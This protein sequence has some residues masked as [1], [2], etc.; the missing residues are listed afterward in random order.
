M[1][2]MAEEHTHY[3]PFTFEGKYNESDDSGGR[4]DIV[5]A[6]NRR[7]AIRLAAM[8]MILDNEWNDGSRCYTSL[9]DAYD[10][11]I[12][13]LH[14]WEDGPG[15][16]CPSCSSMH[17]RDTL[18]DFAGSGGTIHECKSCGFQWVPLGRKLMPE[19]PTEAGID[20]ELDAFQRTMDGS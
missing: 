2:V 10:E 6:Y 9:E 3:R 4:C 8:Q 12:T 11:E 16:V 20:A 14:E 19:A 15:D 18:N 17:S 1:L 7:Q 5:M 13:I